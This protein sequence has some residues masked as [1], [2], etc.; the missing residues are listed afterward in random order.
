MAAQL[1]TYDELATA[2]GVSRE[3]AR[4]KV[5]G[6]HLRRQAGNDGKARVMV[7]LSEVQHQPAK[8]KRDRRAPS[9]RAETEALQQHVE[10]LRGEV[11]R[12][13]ALTASHRADFERERDRAEKVT[14]ELVTQVA[15]LAVLEKE[16]A[17]GV[18]ALQ[19]VQT[20]AEKARAE[21]AEWKSRPW[22]RRALG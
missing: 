10:T 13:L 5:E 15:K 1:M 21:L 22:W 2:W 11:E 6:L 3:A 9:L 20:N 17:E 4:K 12:L 19:M 16:R 18:A 7:D 14:A 8:P